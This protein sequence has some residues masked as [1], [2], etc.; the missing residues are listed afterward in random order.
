MASAE[1]VQHVQNPAERKQTMPKKKVTA[2]RKNLSAKQIKF[3]GTPRLKAAL[4]AKRSKAAQLKPKAAVRKQKHSPR[5]GNPAEVVSL[6][7]GNPAKK[8]GNMAT[9]KQKKKAVARPS[10]AGK[11]KR[12]NTA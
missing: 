4:R 12:P 11:S 2:R 6:L 9:A 8:R 7:L 3:F 10:T 1:I 5:Q